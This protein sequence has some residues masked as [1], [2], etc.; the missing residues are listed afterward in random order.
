M[1]PQSSEAVQVR[2]VIVEQTVVIDFSSKLTVVAFEQSSFA[3]TVGA[4]GNTSEQPIVK[5][6]GTPAK[7]GAFVSMIF[8]Y[9]PNVALFPHS[10]SAIHSQY[11]KCVNPSPLQLSV[12][13]TLSRN[14]TFL[15]FLRTIT[16]P[17]SSVAV[18]EFSSKEGN[19]AQLN[20][21]VS[22]FLAFIIANFGTLI[23]GAFVSFTV[24]VCTLFVALP[25]LS[26]AVKV[27]V[28]V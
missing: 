13:N 21:N 14:S 6:A 17:Q 1:F 18:A 5:L 15:P 7:T 28:M 12:F 16:V 4:V 23:T 10:S 25:Q 11:S 2:V 24:I 9:T 3:V 19:V 20:V 8:M 27:R 26:F 22:P